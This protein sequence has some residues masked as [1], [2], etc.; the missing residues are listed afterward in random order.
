MISEDEFVSL[1]Q[2]NERIIYKVI[3]LYT[4]T[5]DDKQ[6][7]FQETLLQLWKSWHNFEGK[8]SF[9]T[10]MYK[11]TLNVALTFRRKSQGITYESI[12]HFSHLKAETENKEDYEILYLIIKLLPEN[13]RMIITLHLDGYSNEEISD[14]IG[15]S[16]NHTNVKI[17]RAKDT[18]TKLYNKIKDGHQ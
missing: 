18:I 15:I 11:V 7:L 10:W 1:V 2:Q 3:S 8:C 13:D 9:T 6:D 12:D 17:Y 14:M 4:E 5:E 16:R